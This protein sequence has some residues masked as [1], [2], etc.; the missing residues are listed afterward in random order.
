MAVLPE[1]PESY[2]IESAPAPAHPVLSSDVDADVAVVGAGIA[3]VCTA[4]ELAR[5]GRRVALLESDRVVAGTTGHTSAKLTSLHTLRY[6]DIRNAFGADAAR[7]YA[8]SQQGAV[9]RVDEVARELGIDCELERIPA[10]TFVESDDGVAAIEREVDAARDAGLPA[11]FVTESGL[12]FPIAGAIRVD[13]QA[14]FHPRKYLL[15][16][17]DDFAAR[18]GRVFEHSRVVG[19][20]EGEPCTLTTEAGHTVTARDVVVAT[21][22]P[23]F[24]RALLFARLVPHR[25]PVVAAEIPADQDPHGAYLTPE[26]NTRSV[27]TSPYGDGRR[28]LVVTGDGFTPG[29]ADIAERYEALADW[30]RARF[31]GARIAYR[32]A[33]QDN[34]TPD[35]I[36]FIGPFHPGAKHVHVATGFGGWG[37]TN[38]VLA[39]QLLS[40]LILGDRPAWAGLYDPRRLHPLRE[41]GPMLAAQAK[42]ARHFVGDRVR[43][44][45]VSSVA[46]IEPGG[47]AVLRVGGERCAVYRDADGAYQAVSATCS[48]L[49]CIVRFDAD[50]PAWECP[51][52]GSRF[53]TDGSV[54]H[55]PATRPLDPA[56]VDRP[57]G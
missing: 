23:V 24:D 56:D 33:A 48:H 15:G 38:G 27:R 4:W 21:H 12:P 3:G 43:S 53:A 51:C 29:E 30:T 31:P 32:W 40:R 8:Q 28:L 45:P 5:A 44:S 50:G 22:Y 49:G 42:V 16:L 57:E 37:M 54:L 7:D 35:R 2:W 41:A 14:V 9:E 20:D 17:L 47:G 10:Y 25:E 11:T 6:A 39:G 52:H 36:S 19:L 1:K 26:H 18:G 34:G 13:D 46:G 55:G